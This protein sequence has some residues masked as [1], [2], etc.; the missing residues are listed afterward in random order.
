MESISKTALCAFMQHIRKNS[1][2]PVENYEQLHEW[3]VRNPAFFWELIWTCCEVMGS[4]DGLISNNAPDMIDFKFFPMSIFN[5]AENCLRIADFKD[6]D[7]RIIYRCDSKQ[8]DRSILHWELCSTVSL[9]ANAL[10]AHGI[11]KADRVCAVASNCPEAI[12]SM[13]AVGMIGAIWSSVSPDFGKESV[14]CGIEL[15]PGEESVA[16][17]VVLNDGYPELTDNMK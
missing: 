17:F 5:Y 15:K 11:Q 2:V 1:G 9:M 13:L 10:R 8:P 6:D 12:I 3:S 14:C 4:H 7:I 16:L